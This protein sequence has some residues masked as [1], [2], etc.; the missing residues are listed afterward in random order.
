MRRTFFAGSFNP[1]TIG[2]AD[3]VDRALEIFDE[4]VIA[5]GISIDKSTDESAIE[6]LTAPI[7]KLYAGDKRVSVI[8]YSGLTVDAA[9]EAGCGFLLRGVRN[10][11]DF[12]YEK[13][14][15]EV[16]FRLSRI[17]TVILFTRPELAVVSSALVRELEHFG[18]D[19]S[20]FLP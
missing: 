13:E 12:E 19:T 10:V 18:H 17:E 1:F 15:A 3:L 5:V 6:A 2:H 9:K 8:H 20:R 11:K 4:V 7:K 16:N 14:L